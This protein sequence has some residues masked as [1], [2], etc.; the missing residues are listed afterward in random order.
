MLLGILGNHQDNDALRQRVEDVEASLRAHVAMLGELQEQNEILRLREEQH[1]IQLR[2]NTQLAAAAPADEPSPLPPRPSTPPPPP[3]SQALSLHALPASSRVHMAA[4]RALQGRTARALL[5]ATI[6]AWR[7]H[8]EQAAMMRNMHKALMRPQRAQQAAGTPHL[9]H[10]AALRP[11]SPPTP[12]P[13]EMAKSTNPFDDPPAAAPPAPPA[14]PASALA[15]AGTHEP[16]LP[17]RHELPRLRWQVAVLRVLRESALRAPVRTIVIRQGRLPPPSQPPRGHRSSGSTNPFDEPVALGGASSASS[18]KR[19]HVD[20][21]P[22]VRDAR[23]A[24]ASPTAPPA[25]DDN[26]ATATATVAAAASSSAALATAAPDSS[27]AGSAPLPQRLLAWLAPDSPP[28]SGALLHASPA[29]GSHLAATAQGGAAA[30]TVRVQHLATE[31]R[32]LRERL[33]M[34]EA[35][36][37]PLL[38]ELGEKRELL[39]F[40][41]VLCHRA[42]KDAADATAAAAAAAAIATGNANPPLPALDRPEA[43]ADDGAAPVSTEA[44]TAWARGGKAATAAAAQGG[45]RGSGGGASSAVSSSDGPIEVD[46][47]M[48]SVLEETLRRNRKLESDLSRALEAAH[49]ASARRR[50]QVER[51]KP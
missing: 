13:A 40:A 46:V 4:V 28:A 12:Q 10:R 44:I 25:A 3:P 18:S 6:A 35:E 1:L 39:H 14:P 22:S 47:A 37:Q 15:S 30:L 34:V 48:E 33:A 8:C 24:S 7:A 31:N 50:H 27:A 45:G 41:Y 43:L 21:R 9:G 20:G 49:G 51:G 11:P 2:R 17:R 16:Q 42:Q 5:R 26:N 23:L 19:D 32:F 38:T 36:M 29:H